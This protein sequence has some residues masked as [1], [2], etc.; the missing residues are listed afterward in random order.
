[1]DGFG[2]LATGAWSIVP[3]LLALALSLVT[4]EVYSSLAAGVLSGLVIYQFALNGVGIPQFLGAFAMLPQ[5]F[6]QQIANNGALVLFLALLGG[7]TVLIAVAGGSR[8]YARWVTA[9]VRNARVAQVLTALL[10]IFIFIDDYFNCLTVGTVMGPILDR[11]KVSREKLAWIIDSMAAPVCIIA[12]VSSWAVAV[13][14]YLGDDGFSTFVASI[15]YN[16]YAL[17]TVYF[18]LLVTVTGWDFGLMLRAE[19]AVRGIGEDMAAKK[20]GIGQAVARAGI[21][22]KSEAELEGRVR[23]PSKVTEESDIDDAACHSP[24][25]YK[26][27]PVSDR[28]RVADLVVPLLAPAAQSGDDGDR[29]AQAKAKILRGV[30]SDMR[31][32]TTPENQQAMRLAVRSYR[33]RLD[34]ALDCQAS[35]D[36]LRLLRVRT[37]A[38]QLAFVESC[39]TE[40]RTSRAVADRYENALEQ[41]AST[42]EGHRGVS[43]GRGRR[44]AHLLWVARSAAGAATEQERHELAE[45]HVAAE[46]HAIDELRAMEPT[47]APEERRAARIIAGEHRAHLAATWLPTGG[48]DHAAQSPTLAARRARRRETEARARDIE[49]AALSLE[50]EQIRLMH[51]AG[52]LSTHAAR[53]LREEVYL[54]QMGLEVR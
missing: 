54:L 49:A 45:L 44:T 7:L 38:R 46:R 43:G 39:V 42:Y 28:G 35:P 22:D 10:G 31:A 47:L 23:V 25:V 36:T 27:L 15:P 34:L 40:G 29:L 52:E 17:L 37:I 3:P 11:F 21:A 33:D 4:R 6:A 48:D 32:R 30:I 41:L 14:G 26:G 16:L 24:E 19:R 53:E 2:L 9:H 18:V 5:M 20:G 1:M 50:L 12:P 51:D 8:S 13:G